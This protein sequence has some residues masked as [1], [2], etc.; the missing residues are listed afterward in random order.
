MLSE[1][2]CGCDRDTLFIESACESGRQKR[3]TWCLG[4]E[5]GKGKRRGVVFCLR[6]KEFVAQLVEGR[7]RF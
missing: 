1:R 3:R 2:A 7:R 4:G 6:S 5:K